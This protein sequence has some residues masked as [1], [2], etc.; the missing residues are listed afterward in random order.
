MGPSYPI[1]RLAPRSLSLL[2]VEVKGTT[3]FLWI[4][5]PESPECGEL[6]GDVA[7]GCPLLYES[8]WHPY[9]VETVSG[10]TQG[11]DAEPTVLLVSAR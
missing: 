7:V 1:R 6:E 8:S 2:V 9:K 3:V 4:H 5:S 10:S 11:Y